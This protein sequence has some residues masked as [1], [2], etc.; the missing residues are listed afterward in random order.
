[1]S[2]PSFIL[3][4]IAGILFSVLISPILWDTIDTTI[5]CKIMSENIELCLTQ[6]RTINAMLFIGPPGLGLILGL[7]KR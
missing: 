1:M 7:L 2:I 3:Y 6:K 4:L 5:D